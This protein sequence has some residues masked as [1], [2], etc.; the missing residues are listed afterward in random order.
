MAENLFNSLLRESPAGTGAEPAAV[1]QGHEAATSSPTVKTT[2]QATSATRPTSIPR[3]PEERRPHN[4]NSL[5]A[6]PRSFKTAPI[7]ESIVQE[8]TRT[9]ATTSSPPPQPPAT[10]V[11]SETKAPIKT[12][13]T[14]LRS[15]FSR[16]R[17]PFAGRV[18]Q[19]AK[20]TMRPIKTTEAQSVEKPAAEQQ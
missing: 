13:E 1:Q 7:K 19:M 11:S 4:R 18:H 9:T 3:R 6:R 8:T 5:F 14:R 12:E 2:V 16:L 10:T 20:K 15:S 17:S